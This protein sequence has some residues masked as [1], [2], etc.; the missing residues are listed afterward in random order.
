[1]YFCA[2]WV[3]VYQAGKITGRGLGSRALE[4]FLEFSDGGDVDSIGGFLQQFPALWLPAPKPGI[5]SSIFAAPVPSPQP[6]FFSNTFLGKAA[7]PHPPMRRVR[8]YCL[9]FTI[10]I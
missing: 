2:V 7:A 5:F 4:T 9:F 6:R 1:L 10:A 8:K 3:S